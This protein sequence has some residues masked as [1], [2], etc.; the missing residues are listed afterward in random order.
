MRPIPPKLKE[1]LASDPYYKKCCFDFPHVCYGKI[2]WHHNLQF[3]SKQQN[4]KEAI[5]PICQT[6]HD[7]ARNTY[8]KEMLDLIMLE[9]MSKEQR[10]SFSKAVNY[11]NKLQYLRNKYH[12]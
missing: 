4:V 3:A 9:R 8:I 1:E 5:L 2:D 12:N 6:I 11:E 10:L 7:S